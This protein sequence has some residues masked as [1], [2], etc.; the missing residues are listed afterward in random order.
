[1]L[2]WTQVAYIYIY[3]GINPS[4]KDKTRVDTRVNPSINPSIF[5]GFY[6]M[7]WLMAYSL[8]TRVDTRVNHIVVLLSNTRWKL[9]PR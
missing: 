6:G 7:G 3:I 4:Y 2:P 5:D 1:M 8:D 9:V